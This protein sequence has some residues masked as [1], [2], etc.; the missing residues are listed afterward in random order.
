MDEFLGILRVDDLSERK[1]RLGDVVAVFAA[2][3]GNDYFAELLTAFHRVE[4]NVLLQH[5][6]LAEGGR[7]RFE[8]MDAAKLHLTQEIFPELA[9]VRAIAKTARRDAD[10]LTARNEQ[11]LNQCDEAGVEVAR[12]NPCPMKRPSF[13][14]V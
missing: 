13:G 5:A 2:T 12:L 1:D 7:A 3:T 9:E 4:D 14:R 10:E 11:A 8:N 6:V